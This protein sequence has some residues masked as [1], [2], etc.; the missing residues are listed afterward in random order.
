MLVSDSK[1]NIM[2]RYTREALLHHDSVSPELVA[3]SCGVSCSTTLL[4][5]P[6]ALRCTS[7]YAVDLAA[8]EAIL[9]T[10]FCC[11]LYSISA[12]RQAKGEGGGAV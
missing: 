10:L 5:K 2:L 6:P 3:V 7:Y 8:D 9:I 1:V 11:V 4:S 12:G